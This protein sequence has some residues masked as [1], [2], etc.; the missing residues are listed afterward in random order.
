MISTSPELSSSQQH[1]LQAWMRFSHSAIHSL[2]PYSLAGQAAFWPPSWLV[3][4]W[5][6]PLPNSG[7]P[8]RTRPNSPKRPLPSTQLPLRCLKHGFYHVIRTRGRACPVIPNPSGKREKSRFH[9]GSTPSE[10][11]PPIHPHLL[12]HCLL[13]LMFR[14]RCLISSAHQAQFRTR[15]D[16]ALEK[17]P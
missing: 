7:T 2:G 4:E 12:P 10:S 16:A 13:S 5:A 17:G 9:S 1:L 3:I 15:T 8:G 14:A 6:E 11:P